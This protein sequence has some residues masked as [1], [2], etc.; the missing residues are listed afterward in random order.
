MNYEEAIALISKLDNG[1]EIANAI[2][3]KVKDSL[4][5]IKE[6]KKARQIAESLVS[7]IAEVTK[8]EGNDVAEKA[9]SAKN[10]LDKLIAD[11]ATL[12]RDKES[13]DKKVEELQA[14]IGKF[15]RR[16]KL[17]NAVSK[18]G[19]EANKVAFLNR[20]LPE[21][22]EIEVTD[23]GVFIGENKTE[24]KKYL[25]TEA[26]DTVSYIY[27]KTAVDNIREPGDQAKFPVGGN[28]EATPPKKVDLLAGMK[29]AIPGK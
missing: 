16:D 8:A 2:R 21:N 5:Q 27:S 25:S 18:A 26:P 7:H 4:D 23:K 12:A 24:L 29:F 14:K 10:K 3:G 6:E 11:Q 9:A 19:I 22:I 28:D 1:T 13:A 15:E 20:I 17:S